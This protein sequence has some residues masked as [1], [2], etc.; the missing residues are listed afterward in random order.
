MNTFTLREPAAGSVSFRE[1]PGAAGSV[2]LVGY[3]GEPFEYGALGRIVVDLAAVTFA[4]DRYPLLREHDRGRVLGY[5]SRPTVSNGRLL[6]AGATLVD[7]RDASEVGNLLRSGV[8]MEASICLTD[9]KRR[10][11]ARGEVEK[12]NGRTVT[13]PATI[14]AGTFRECSVCVL[15]ADSRTST[16]AR[17]SFSDDEGGE[18][19]EE[20][21]LDL[22]ASEMVL[23]L[24]G[25]KAE[26]D[27][28]G[29]ELRTCEAALGIAFAP[30]AL[31]TE[32]LAA[33]VES[34]M[35]GVLSGG[36]P[37]RP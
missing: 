12:V 21:Y 36:R 11:L 4:K 19:D 7:T 33:E 13:G 27:A 18:P 31:D 26:A 6:I 15:G 29:G 34:M 5:F 32:A 20:R 25:R 28:L 35:L 8:P 3:S 10:T 30:P 17:F 14:L 22:L 37:V 2:D 1:A 24:Q 9:V 16:T 23:R